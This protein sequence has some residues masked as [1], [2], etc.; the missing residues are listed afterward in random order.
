MFTIAKLQNRKHDDQGEGSDHRVVGT[1]P[2]HRLMDRVILEALA[3]TR[4]RPPS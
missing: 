1:I 2:D 4:G 3:M